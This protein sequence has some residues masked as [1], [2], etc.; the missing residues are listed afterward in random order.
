M[1]SFNKEIDEITE[2]P[3]RIFSINNFFDYNF[4]LD[5]GKLFD[6]LEPKELYLTKNFGKIFIKSD[7]KNH[8]NANQIWDR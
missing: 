2:N 5:I 1:D 3:F 8:N 7:F 4:Y 6:K